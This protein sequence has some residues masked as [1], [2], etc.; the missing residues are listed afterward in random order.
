MHDPTNVQAILTG[1]RRIM[2]TIDKTIYE[3]I[4][5]LYQIF[6]NVANSTLISGETIKAFFSRVQL[7]LGIIILFRL[8][9]SLI[10]GI[11][12]PDNILD[13]KNGFS[14]IITRVVVCLIMLVLIVPLNI[15]EEAITDGSYESQ[16]NN[17]GILFGTLYEF[18]N[19]I[20]SE[21]T[22]AK[23]IF[24]ED[25]ALDY[26]SANNRDEDSGDYNIRKSGE[27]LSTLLAKSFVQINMQEGQEE[28]DV[29]VAENRICAG[30]DN[31]LHINAYLDEDASSYTVFNSVDLSCAVGSSEYYVFTYMVFFSTAAGVFVVVILLGF[32]LDIAIRSIKL[33]ILRLIA[34][35]PIISYIDPKSENG[36]FSAWTKAVTKTYIDLFIRLAVI[37]LILFLIKEFAD[38]GIVMEVGTGM[39]GIMSRLFIYLG[40]FFFAREAP[41]FITESL[42]IKDSGNF[43]TGVTRMLGFTAAAAGTIGAGI[44]AGRASYMADSA[45]DKKHNIA[46]R[47]KN[48][49]AGILGGG[50]GLVS[51]VNATA[52]A[53]DHHARAALDAIAKRN[54]TALAA[55]DAGSTAFGRASSSLSRTLFGE[56][57]AAR[58]KR[59]ISNL[60]AQQSALEAVKSRMSSEMVKQDWT[61]GEIEKG[62]NIKVN[63]KSFKAT[64]DAAAAAGK[65]KFNYVDINGNTKEITMEKANRQI[66]YILKENE[67]SYVEGI[68]AGMQGRKY[69]FGN[70]K[71]VQSDVVLTESIR[72]AQAKNPGLTIK[73]RGDITSTIDQRAVD[74]MAA[75]RANAKNEQNDRFSNANK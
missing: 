7:I 12:N 28:G 29:T 8:C 53:K 61:Y 15:P 57:A 35:A 10:N 27:Q 68:V 73:N 55:G 70:N 41:K 18:Q 16:L 11:I 20:L 22:F 14:S 40:L 23:L 54:A 72:D 37:Y 42:G 43:F 33:A 19:R 21:N 60:E 5:S 49:A 4:S 58:G 3:L 39:V 31:P 17:N 67:S 34:P 32:T 65:E 75:K 56:T 6:F 48:V 64:M 24:G 46:R 38:P 44:A 25:V 52:T 36:A 9:L 1:F 59:Y 47:A 66:G 71:G 69:G 63:Y 2:A 45:N 50:M 62:S 30:N 13:K 51:G 26:Q 74:V